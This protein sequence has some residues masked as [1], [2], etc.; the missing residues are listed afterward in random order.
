MPYNA[1]AR[2]LS[3]TTASNPVSLR[4]SR[5]KLTFI[6]TRVTS[7]LHRGREQWPVILEDIIIKG[8]WWVGDRIN[9]N[10]LFPRLDGTTRFFS[11]HQGNHDSPRIVNIGR[12]SL[13]NN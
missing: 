8:N 4:I 7:E 12:Y 5:R 1:A 10:A 2:Q 6:G 11:V 3:L 9:P 13:Q